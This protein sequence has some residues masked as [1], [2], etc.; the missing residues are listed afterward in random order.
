VVMKA[1]FILLLVVFM[2][3]FGGY[4]VIGI[5]PCAN[6][7][8]GYYYQHKG[9][10]QTGKQV[11]DGSLVDVLSRVWVSFVRQCALDD[12]QL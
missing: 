8:D 10:C 12:T 2:A 6:L 7:R 5:Q 3:C 9:N 11:L 4:G 1:G